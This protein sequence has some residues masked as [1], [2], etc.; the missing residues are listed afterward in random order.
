M[1]M[2]SVSWVKKRNER[3]RID[4][5]KC[6]V[7]GSGHDLNVH[8]LTYRNFMHE[9]VG[10]DLVTLCRSCHAMPHRVKDQSADLYQGYREEKDPQLREGRK[11]QLMK[12]LFKLIIVE[13]WQRD[14][15]AGSDVR[16]FDRGKRMIGRLLQIPKMI[17]PELRRDLWMMDD[18]IKDTLGIFRSVQVVQAYRFGTSL[19]E[20]AR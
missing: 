7:C 14:V 3:I 4:E 8:H 15:S 13:I 10:L 5:G 20:V 6:A 18:G 12:L 17:H 1:Y 19:S 11:R 2:N 9:D 16:V